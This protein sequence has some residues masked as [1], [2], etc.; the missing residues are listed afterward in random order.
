MISVIVVWALAIFFFVLASL[1]R[2]KIK[3]LPSLL[4]TLSITFFALLIPHGQVLLSIGSF[5][6]T[7]DSLL[8]GLKR[9]G[10]LVGMVFFSQFLISP[11]IKLPG[12]AG[13][14]LKQVFFWLEKLT[15]IKI[16]FKPG[17]II[18]SIDSRLCEIWAESG[19]ITNSQTNVRSNNGD[20]DV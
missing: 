12:K 13:I 17:H 1:K 6:I 3:I 10:I 8:L 20:S 14:F 15:S 9:S 2:K 7:L 11:T 18:E 4:I 5:R 16:S 19:E